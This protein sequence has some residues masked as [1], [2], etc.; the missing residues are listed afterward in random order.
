MMRA[1]LLLGGCSCCATQCTFRNEID[2]Y[3]QYN[4]LNGD[5]TARSSDACKA[6][7]CRDPACQVWQ[8]SDDPATAPNCWSGASD[9]YGDSGG[10][11]WQG[12]QGKAA[13]PQAQV[14]CVNNTCVAAPAGVPGM[15]N[16]TCAKVCEPVSA[17]CLSALFCNCG[18][19][20]AK[21]GDPSCMY[22][23]GTYQYRLHVAGCAASDI[24]G[25]CAAPAPP[26]PPPVD[27]STKGSCFN[28]SGAH[29]Y[30]PPVPSG[31]DLNGEYTK[32][33]HTCNGKPVYH[34]GGSGGPVLF[35]DASWY[36][37][38]G[39]SERAFDCNC[40]GSDVYL[41]SGDDGA[42]DASPDGAG[43]AAKWQEW[44]SSGSGHPNPALRV[45]ASGG[46]S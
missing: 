36:W 38:V 4:D 44:D 14:R 15:D 42:C 6:N 32:T 40:L 21:G 8:W 31:T 3:T 41:W 23:A 19:A 1:L 34:H 16:A 18:A 13:A 5:S 22:C 29:N 20:R 17:V 43:C 30:H 27:C 37:F 7:C 33:A 2:P 46:H 24:A 25:F 10:V 28:I 11:K 26:A 35:Q 12:E 39:P 45:V 9:N